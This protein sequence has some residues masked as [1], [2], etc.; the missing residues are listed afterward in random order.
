MTRELLRTFKYKLGKLQSTREKFSV[1]GTNTNCSVNL[2]GMHW[3]LCLDLLD[4][5]LK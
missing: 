5:K 2:Y 1:E 4:K 3:Q